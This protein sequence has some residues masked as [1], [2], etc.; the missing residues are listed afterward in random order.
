MF[1]PLYRD[2][3]TLRRQI[4]PRS[5]KGPAEHEQVLDDAG[6]P[7]S[8]RCRITQGGRRVYETEG[9]RTLGDATMTFRKGDALEP[10]LGDLVVTRDGQTYKVLRI[11]PTRPIGARR[12]YAE[13][14]LEKSAQKVP[15][16]AEATEET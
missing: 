14:T 1:G 6:G 7:L 13:A 2:V 12:T 3:V 5:R 15:A 16:D 9:A 8:M 4:K 11:D 10:G